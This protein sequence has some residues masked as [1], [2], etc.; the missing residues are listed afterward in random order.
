PIPVGTTEIAVE[1]CYKP[2]GTAGANDYIAFA[3]VQLVRNPANASFSN[4]LAGYPSAT[5]NLTL[6]A[7]DRRSQGVE[8]ALQQRY[9]YRITETTAVTM[10]GM[11]VNLTS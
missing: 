3:G 9:Y 1:L 10:R 11:C 4:P 7:F 5:T 6:T 2:V 8:T